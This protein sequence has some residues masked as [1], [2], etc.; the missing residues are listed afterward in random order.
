MSTEADGWEVPV[1]RSLVR[2]MLLLGGEREP[3]MMLGMISGIFILSLFRWWTVA[4]GVGLWMVG[5]F[6]L[7][8]IAEKDPIM[9]KTFSR[10]LKYRKFIPAASTPFAVN[11]EWK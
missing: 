9:S 3:V 7:Q 5:L 10:S 6:F 4:I 11:S 8:R 1:H 2:P